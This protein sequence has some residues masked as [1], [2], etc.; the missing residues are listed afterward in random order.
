[1]IIE[2]PHCDSRVECQVRGE[3]Q[4]DA[5]YGGPPSKVVLLQCKVCHSPL[6]GITEML[7][8]GENEYEWDAPGRL[9]PEPETNLDWGIPEIARNSLV[10][11]KVCF[12]AKAYSACASCAAEPSKAYASTMIQRSGIFKL[13]CKNSRKMVSSTTASTTGAMPFVLAG[14]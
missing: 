3:V 9:W 4:E 1:M 12:K 11:A 2:C 6:L 10:E 5:E 7:Q 8:V 14:T 13:A